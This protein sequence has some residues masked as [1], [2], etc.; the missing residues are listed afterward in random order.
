MQMSMAK[1]LMMIDPKFNKGFKFEH[2]WDMVKDFN[3]FQCN[4]QKSRADKSSSQ[5]AQS[6][7]HVSESPL[8]PTTTPP[9][10]VQL[11]DDSGSGSGS[12][13]QRP[14]GVK[15]TK[16]KKKK[17]EQVLNLLTTLHESTE[18]MHDLL[19]ARERKKSERFEM[20][21]A[22]QQKFNANYEI[23]TEIARRESESKIMM[24]DLS[25]IE[26][27]GTRSYFENEKAKILQRQAAVAAPPHHDDNFNYGDYFPD[28]GGDGSGTGLGDF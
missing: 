24:M 8:S 12:A 2:V 10:S 19:N 28:M 26:D 25:S 13:S 4:K 1:Q 21:M 27:P 9:F 3:K 14:L 16:L 20:R 6:S 22:A 5:S 18:K 7:T 11:S 23:N 15:K 17:G